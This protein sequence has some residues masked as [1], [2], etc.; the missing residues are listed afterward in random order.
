MIKKD[1]VLSAK[2]INNFFKKINVEPAKY[3]GISF[4]VQ[5]DEENKNKQTWIIS[6]ANTSFSNY[7]SSQYGKLEWNS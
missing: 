7:N 1:K 3:V 6:D 2:D 5:V 4:P